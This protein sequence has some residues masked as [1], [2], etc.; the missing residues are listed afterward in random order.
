MTY[1]KDQ[2]IQLG[3]TNINELSDKQIWQFIQRHQES[4]IYRLYADGNVWFEDDF[5]EVDDNQPYYDDYSTYVIPVHLLPD[6]EITEKDLLTTFKHFL[7]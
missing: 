2:A 4:F 1:F 3:C 6:D 7:V 5:D